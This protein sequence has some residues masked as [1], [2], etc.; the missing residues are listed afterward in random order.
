MNVEATM[1][2][3]L[4]PKYHQ[5]YLESP[6][7]D[8]L[9]GFADW[10]VSAGYAHDPA[11]DHV[12]RLKLVL[13]ARGSVTPDT[14]FSVAELATMFTSARQQPLLRGTRRA[15]L[16]PVHAASRC[17]PA[18]SDRDARTGYQYDQPTPYKRQ[19]L[20]CSSRAG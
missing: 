7:A 19:S 4:F 11:H 1:L 16:Q 12:R 13:E 14:V 9:A 2:T 8:W 17:V 3:T 10:L 18:S 6:V 5:R 15:R 20:S